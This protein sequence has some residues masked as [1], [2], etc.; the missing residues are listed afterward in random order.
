MTIHPDDIDDPDVLVIQNIQGVRL[1]T[2]APVANVLLICT[3]TAIFSFFGSGADTNNEDL[4]FRIPDESKKAID[5]TKVVENKPGV[6]F[7]SEA[8]VASLTS[9]TGT[10]NDGPFAVDSV[11]VTREGDNLQLTAKL[12]VG[13]DSTLSRMAYQ[14][15]ILLAV[16]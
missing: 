1:G 3:G 10:D 2:S 13:H 14:A 16:G 8:T 5:L 12:A 6:T 15:N 9:F 11:E 7:V 4:V